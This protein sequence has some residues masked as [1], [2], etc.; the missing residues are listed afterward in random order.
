MTHTFDFSKNI[1]SYYK[2][3]K[4]LRIFLKSCLGKQIV[5]TD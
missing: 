4:Y 3:A 2:S 1:E 5:Q